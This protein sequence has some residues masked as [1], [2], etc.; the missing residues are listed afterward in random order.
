MRECVRVCVR[1]C[2]RMCVCACACAR[3]CVRACVYVCANAVC[4]E[5]NMF[6]YY[7]HIYV[8]ILVDFVKRNVLTLVGA[9]LRYCKDH[10]YYCC[11][12]LAYRERVQR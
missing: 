12:Y 4:E 1:A 7:F 11:Y 9:I 5:H 10:Y 2:G 8:L 3:V 6:K